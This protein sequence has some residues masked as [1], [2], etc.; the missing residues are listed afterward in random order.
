MLG[1][2]LYAVIVALALAAGVEIGFLQWGTEKT[3]DAGYGEQGTGDREWTTASPV[4]GPPCPVPGVLASEDPAPVIAAKPA[5]KRKKLAAPV[6]GSGDALAE[7]A[8]EGGPLCGMP[9]R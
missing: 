1:R 2:S 5:K 6:T 7:C 9:S 8:R 4:P 3:Q